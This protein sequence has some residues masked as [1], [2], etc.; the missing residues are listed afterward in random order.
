M[1]NAATAII[2]LKGFL[3]IHKVEVLW[4]RDESTQLGCKGLYE[5]KSMSL[6]EDDSNFYQLGIETTAH[7]VTFF[8]S[9]E[10]KSNKWSC[11]DLRKM[12]QKMCLLGEFFID[13]TAARNSTFFLNWTIFFRKIIV[14]FVH[15]GSRLTFVNWRQKSCFQHMSLFLFPCAKEKYLSRSEKL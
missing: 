6:W 14:L 10:R 9:L 8:G 12:E 15:S 2:S 13:F 11:C 1:Q 3:K 5:N 4:D 7:K